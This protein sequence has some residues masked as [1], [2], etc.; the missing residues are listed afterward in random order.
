MRGDLIKTL[1]LI[2]LQVLEADKLNLLLPQRGNLLMF[3]AL[4]PLVL[5]VPR[6]MLDF[7]ANGVNPRNLKIF[8]HVR[9]KLFAINFANISKKLCQ[10]GQGHQQV[11]PK[12]LHFPC[13]L[14]INNAEMFSCH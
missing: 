3:Y 9:F 5:T 14:K 1:H 2:L 7:P 6:W 8:E 12:L 13:L 4:Q 10:S 11:N